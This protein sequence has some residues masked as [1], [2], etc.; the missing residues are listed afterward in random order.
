MRLDLVRANDQERSVVKQAVILCGGGGTRLGALTAAMPKPLLPVAGAP[1]LDLLLFELGRHGIRRIVLL[2]GYIARKIAEYAA[3][4]PIKDRFGLE[5]DVAVE[6]EPAGTGGALALAKD[7]LDDSFL[8]LNGDSWF[9]INLLGLPALLAREPDAVGCLALRAVADTARYG[10]VDLDDGRITGFAERPGAM[11]PGVINGGIGAFRRVLLDHIPQ[12][13]S[14]EKD[15]FPALARAGRLRGAPHDG[16]F[17]DIGIPADF[18]RAQT[19]IARQQVR[20][21]AFLDRDGVLNHDDGYIGSRE[22]FRWIE[23]AREAVK[24]LNDAGLFVFLVTNQS[25]IGRGF[26]SEDEFLSL[27]GHIATELAAAGGHLD[28]VRF[29]PYHPE[30]ALPAYRRASDWRKPGPGML[31]DLMRSW[32]VDA[33][34]SFMIGDSRGDMAAAA[35]A[36]I[37]GHLFAGGRLDAFVEKILQGR[38]QRRG[39]SRIVLSDSVRATAGL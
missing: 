18:E 1:F 32:P 29:C 6:A 27:H 36:G 21:A 11:G 14:L 28:D 25:G 30:A 17:I 35:A 3:A 8:L 23:G 19:E 15:V 26:Y 4:T 9:D 10:V 5:I 31:L 37:A 7:R 34:A 22:R 38:A 33:A 24:A 13:A 12:K 2:A 39:P 20:A 16:Y